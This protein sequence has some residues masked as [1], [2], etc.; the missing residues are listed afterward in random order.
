ME[1][2]RVLSVERWVRV[3]KRGERGLRIEGR[4]GV[5][6]VVRGAKGCV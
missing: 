3:R 2:A 6:W 5:G 1:A 4:S